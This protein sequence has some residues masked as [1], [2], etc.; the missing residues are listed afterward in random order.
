VAAL[1]L[2]LPGALAARTGGTIYDR[3]ITKGLTAR[4]WSVTVHSLDP[5]F[6]LAPPAAIAA[7]RT[8]VESLPPGRLVV[9][10]G[11]VLGPGTDGLV[12]AAAPLCPVALVHHPLALEGGLDASVRRQLQDAERAAWARMR[13]LIVTSRWTAAALAEAGIDAERIRIVEPG[14]ARASL[15]RGSRGG[16]LNLLCVASLT[17]RKGHAVLFDALAG[18]TAHE[19]RLRCAGSTERD[20][21]T[22]A[23]LA[24]QADR[25][26]LG[27][28][29]ELLG[30]LSEA[31]LAREYDDA[32]LFVLSSQLEGYG[33][34]A[35]EALAHGLPVVATAAGALRD[36]L[37]PAARVLVPPGDREALAAALAELF[38]DRARLEQL[39]AAAR[40]AR[41]ALPSWGDAS[42]AFAAALQDLAG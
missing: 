22:A 37:P 2:L 24:A 8:V 26:G 12:G 13:R 21:R 5:A 29:I 10:D 6:P 28:R 40:L 33:M 11:L 31:A 16:G 39:A 3:R 25:L 41:D 15:A 35:A 34:A 38:T 7:A 18:L 42:A 32:D 20:P 17:P 19:W 23:A 14:T 27:G 4:G 36:T 1:D 30:E 9:F